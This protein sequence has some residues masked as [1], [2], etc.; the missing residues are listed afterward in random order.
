MADNIPGKWV[1]GDFFPANGSPILYHD[2][3][4]AP[5]PE[6]VFTPE[7]EAR[8]EEMIAEATRELRAEVERLQQR[9]GQDSE[10]W[11]F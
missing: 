5:E 8:V 9:M 10:E 6:P 1:N 4:P 7:Q 2:P 11:R 3:N